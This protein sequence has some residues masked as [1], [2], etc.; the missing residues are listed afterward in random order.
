MTAIVRRGVRPG[1]A[2]AVVAAGTVAGVAAVY[3][4][5]VLGGGLLSGHTESPNLALCVL[6]TAIVA[7]GLEPGR[8]ALARLSA[9]R[10][11]RDPRSP[12]DVLSGFTESVI[13]DLDATGAEPVGVPSRMARLLAQATGAQWAQVWLEVEGRSELS[14]TWPPEH[15]DTRAGLRVRTCEVSL[16][17]ERLGTLRLGERVDQPLGPV[18][19]RLFSGL[20]A[21]AGPVLLR[22]RLQRELAQRAQELELRATE[23]QGS[24]RRLVETQDVERRRLERDIHD[25]AQQH[26]VALVV[27]LRLA[28]TLAER[29]PERSRQVLD[30]QVDAIDT[31]VHALADL[32]RGLYPR[33]LAEDGVAAALRTVLA[34]APVPVRVTDHGVGRGSAEVEAAL[35]FCAVEA[36]QNAVK[37]AGPTSVGVE[38]SADGDLVR[39]VVRDDGTGFDPATTTAGRGL[40][41]MRD[42]IDAVKGRLDLRARPGHGV[43]VVATV[44]RG[45]SGGEP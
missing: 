31:A 8:E 42:R 40:G 14:V 11:G 19:E 43:E 38:L 3:V 30:E 39:L 29:A 33:A 26:L 36:V 34:A 41:N 4:V 16:E 13:T 15:A 45:S 18:E 32:S 7:L 28:Q 24:R 25:G 10:S 12:Y 21:Q 20:A 37:H 22:A 23:L 1:R 2:E 5:V 27:N 17:G 6:A 9:R 35:Y 44:P